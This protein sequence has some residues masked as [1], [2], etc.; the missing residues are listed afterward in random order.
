MLTRKR[1]DDRRL[2]DAGGD[3]LI[4]ASPDEAERGYDSRR[5]SG[6]PSADHRSVLLVYRPGSRFEWTLSWPTHSR[7]A[8]KRS[9]AR[10]ARLPVPRFASTWSALRERRLSWRQVI[11]CVD[12]C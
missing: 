3:L 12:R 8:L 6:S 9:I 4:E 7:P 1:R 5:P 11:R 2:E 10:S